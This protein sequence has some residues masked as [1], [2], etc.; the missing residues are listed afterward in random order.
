ML[1]PTPQLPQVRELIERDH[2]F[3]LHAPRQTGKTTILD[4]LASDLTAE[5][6][7]AA[8]SFSCERAKIFSDD[9]AA[10]ETILLDSLR[11][12]ANLSGLSGELLPPDSWPEEQAGTRFGKAL[13]AWC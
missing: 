11:E 7:I 10:T 12:T 3:V 1:P 9:I 6:D 4:A 5:G 2:Y 8:L 13:S